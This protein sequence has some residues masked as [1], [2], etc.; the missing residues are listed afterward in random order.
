MKRLITVLILIPLYFILC[1][2]VGVYVG[3]GSGVTKLL[4]RFEGNANDASGNSNNGTATSVTYGLAYGRFSQGANFNGT[5]GT[6]IVT[7]AVTVATSGTVSV[8]FKRQGTLT[9]DRYLFRADDTGNPFY[10][11]IN[12][13]VI[14]AKIDDNTILNALSIFPND[15]TTWHNIIMTWDN[16]ASP[17]EV[18]YL[19]GISKATADITISFSN[20]YTNMYIGSSTSST[21]AWSGYMDEFILENV[22][23]NASKVKKYYS[24]CKGFFR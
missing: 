7:G 8:W 22:A 4:Y 17:K 24:W 20:N 12:D 13:N 15:V 16:T 2:S 19:D 5:D 21:S 9:T 18:F 3:A 23:W 14:L 11:L 10:M 6:K 1:S